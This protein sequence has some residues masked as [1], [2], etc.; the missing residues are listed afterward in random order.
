M[1]LQRPLAAISIASKLPSIAPMLYTQLINA[2]VY[3]N[4]NEYTGVWYRI[5]A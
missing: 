5:E 3:C 2:A 4:M 1:D